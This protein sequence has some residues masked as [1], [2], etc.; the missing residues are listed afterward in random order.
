MRTRSSSGAH[1][2]DGHSNHDRARPWQEGTA[3]RGQ[4]HGREHETGSVIVDLAAES[5][6]SCDLPRPERPS[7]TKGSESSVL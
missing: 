7:S 5:G 1:G 4:G 2:G 6:G 3:A